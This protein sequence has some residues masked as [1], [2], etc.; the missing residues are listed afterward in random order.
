MLRTIE[1]E[2]R[3]KITD[4]T[5]FVDLDFKQGKRIVDKYLDTVN[6]D[7]YKK[8]IFIRNRNGKKLDFKFNMESLV[9]K[10]VKSDHSHCD[11]YSFSI[12]FVVDDI[13]KMAEV[14][15]FLQLKVPAI[16]DYEHFLLEK[17][18]S[19]LVV[20][21]KQRSHVQKGGFDLS[22][23]NIKDA[24]WF[25]EIEKIVNVGIDE[26]GLTERLELTKSEIGNYA[27][28]IGIKGEK[29]NSGYVEIILR[30]L[31]YDIY[32]QGKYLLKEDL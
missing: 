2:S 25:I 30:K 4:P 24:G 9:N 28:S 17:E 3:Y 23:D 15:S 20:V 26:I 8:G 27:K 31:K 1:V 7:L 14:C 19:E 32:I 13:D 16:F 29:F 12:P 10:K 22:L 21:D 18:L 6:G 11:E 5:K